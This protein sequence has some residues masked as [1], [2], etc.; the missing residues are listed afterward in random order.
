MRIEAVAAYGLLLAS[1]ASPHD[2]SVFNITAANPKP[3]FDVKIQLRGKVT[4]KLSACNQG[5]VLENIDWAP[6]QEKCGN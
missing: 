2:G 1:L 4:D 5:L 3:P 6:T